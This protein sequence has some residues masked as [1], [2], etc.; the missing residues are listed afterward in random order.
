MAAGRAV[1]D[2][3][4][5]RFGRA[6]LV[7]AGGLVAALGL[8][9]ALAIGGAWAGV[10]GFG[11][12]GIGMSVVFPIVL[13]EAGRLSKGSPGTAIAAVATFGYAGFLAGPP[14]IGF[15]GAAL[16]LRGGLAAVVAT[17]LVIV[18]LSR[19]LGRAPGSPAVDITPAE[20]A[21]RELAA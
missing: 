2:G 5:L 15:L 18:A 3:L 14:L 17:S 8:A 4:T 11:A 1:G 12:V 9:A 7:G 16:T 6:R 13:G 20:P 10:V 19:T 21:R